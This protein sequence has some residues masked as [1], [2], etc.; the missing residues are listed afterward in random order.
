MN[1]PEFPKTFPR[2]ETSRL[3]LRRITADDR[4]GI[5]RNFSDP[6]VAKWFFEEPFTRMEQVDEIIQAFGQ[7]FEQGKG[8]T[9]AIALKGSD[10]FVGTCG[11]G[12]VEVGARGEIGF[13]LAREHWGQGLMNEALG[14][15]V[16]YGFDVFGLDKVEA[17]T[18]SA[19]ARAIRLLKKLGF[20]LERVGD[21]AYYFSLSRRDW[22]DPILHRAREAT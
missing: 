21:D 20:Q 8:L 11:Y 7:E 2:L 5:L 17:H 10:E 13:D 1:V 19:N 18:Y 3:I 16:E 22:R 14:A 9:W 6:E 4:A 12:E 15:I